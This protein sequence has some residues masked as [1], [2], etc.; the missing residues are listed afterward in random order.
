ML[1]NYEEVIVGGKCILVPYRK[2]HVAV[3]HVWMQDPLMLEATASDPLTRDEE[4]EM[5]E[6]WR[7]DPNKCTYI[8]LAKQ[9]VDENVLQSLAKGESSDFIQETLSAMAGD[10]NMFLSQIEEEIKSDDEHYQV[11]H[12]TLSQ[13][14]LEPT[15][16]EIDIMIAAP[17]YQRQGLGREAICLT[18]HYLVSRHLQVRR[19]FCKIKENN[20]ASLQLFRSL[21]FTQCAY[22]ACFKE[23][24]LELKRDSN[25]D[26]LQV[27]VEL[28]EPLTI[29]QS[30]Q[31]PLKSLESTPSA[32]V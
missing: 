5:Q 1:L 28:L 27:L 22:A 15:Q 19:V 13:E 30:F 18:M 10:V 4:Y 2:E 14:S 6:T 8:V 3:Y 11:S 23:V 17:S 26:L 25:E 24:E 21:G 12:A 16:A 9:A 20:S 32:N 29:I 31:C 7:D